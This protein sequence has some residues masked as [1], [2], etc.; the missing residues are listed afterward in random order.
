MIQFTVSRE[1][2]QQGLTQN[3]RATGRRTESVPFSLDTAMPWS[4][5]CSRPT[6][7]RRSRHRPTI[8]RGCAAMTAKRSQPCLCTQ[9]RGICS[10]LRDGHAQVLVFAGVP[11]D[12]VLAAIARDPCG[13]THAAADDPSPGRTRTYP[14][15]SWPPACDLPARG[16]A[17]TAA[18]VT[19]KSTTRRQPLPKIHSVAYRDRSTQLWDT[20]GFASIVTTEPVMDGPLNLAAI[21]IAC[22]ALSWRVTINA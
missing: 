1:V 21:C 14:G 20:T 5:L 22:D 16:G 6:G 2:A 17:G 8:Q 19:F 11:I 4:A 13:E 12:L 18:T 15:P 7:A 10:Q 9:C 3:L